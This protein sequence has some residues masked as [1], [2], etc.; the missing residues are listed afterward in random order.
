MRPALPALLALACLTGCVTL[1]QT[2]QDFLRRHGVSGPLYDRMLHRESLSLADIIELSEKKV[3][4]TFLIQYLRSTVAVYRLGSDDVLLLRKAGVNRAVID[5]LLET[6]ALAASV[7]T[8]FWYDDP[9]WWGAYP[10]S[11]YHGGVRHGH[12]DHH[13]HHHHG[14]HKH[15]HR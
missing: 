11:Y 6:P 9:F 5:Y 3:S 2:D 10:R 8:P 12:R 13:H 1:S 15:R 14:G 7:A 4:P